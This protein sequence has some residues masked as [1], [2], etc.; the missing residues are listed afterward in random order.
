GTWEGQFV[1]PSS[2]F[3]DGDEWQLYYSASSGGPTYEVGLATVARDRLWHLRRQPGAAH[4]R[5]I[6]RPLRR[7]P[8]GWGRYTLTVNASCLHRASALRLALLD[9]ATRQPIPGYGWAEAVPVTQD[10]FATAVTWHPAGARLPDTDG[11]LCIGVEAEATARLHA[12]R[13]QP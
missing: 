8:G 7:P 6:S 2:G 4:P 10:G 5:A 12:L 1:L 3:E 11:D 13:L 9:P